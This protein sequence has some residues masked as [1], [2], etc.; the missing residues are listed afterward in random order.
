MTRR[1]ILLTLGLTLTLMAAS[2]GVPLRLMSKTPVVGAEEARSL[3][4]DHYGL[5]WIGT[6]QGVRSFDGYDFKTY[7][8]DA[9]SPFIKL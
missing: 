7:R 9:Y 1:L 6:D 8:S 4:F 5:M 3:L 2:Q